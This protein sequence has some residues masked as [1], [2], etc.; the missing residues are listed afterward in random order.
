[1]TSQDKLT[2]ALYKMQ[3]K[4]YDVKTEVT[5]TQCDSLLLEI[6]SDKYGNEEVLISQYFELVAVFNFP[7]DEIPVSLSSTQNNQNPESTNVLHLYDIVPISCF[8][9]SEDLQK[10]QIIIGSVILYKIKLM[11]GNFQII[12]FQIIDCVAKGNQSAILWQQLTVAPLLNY[13][14]LNN[15][16]YKQIV[17]DFKNKNTF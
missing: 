14:L 8:V 3:L 11:D 7:E 1:M 9:K 12:P 13:E 16:T 17:E 15:E 6:N 2:R 10:L 4:L 5:G